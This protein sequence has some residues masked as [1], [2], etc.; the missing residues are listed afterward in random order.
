MVRK[1]R[2]WET[3]KKVIFNDMGNWGVAKIVS[4]GERSESSRW[5]WLEVEKTLDHIAANRR[6]LV[7]ADDLCSYTDEKWKVISEGYQRIKG[8]EEEKRQLMNRIV[9]AFDEDWDED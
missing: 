5:Y 2:D 6:R 7:R 3:G 9:K 4:E 1:K 8:L